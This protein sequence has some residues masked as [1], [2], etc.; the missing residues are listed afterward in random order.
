M[1]CTR[2]GH[3]HRNS[4]PGRSRHDGDCNH[5]SMSGGLAGMEQRCPCA[6]PRCDPPVPHPVDG[7]ASENAKAY[8]FN[9][10]P[11]PYLGDL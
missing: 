1:I 3:V 5:L 2:C 7:D 11:D 6:S 9:S 4:W 10:A 8:A